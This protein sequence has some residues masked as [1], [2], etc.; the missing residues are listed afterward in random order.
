[1]GGP[2]STFCGTASLRHLLGRWHSARC[3]EGEL[4]QPVK[5]GQKERD[6]AEGYGVGAMVRPVPTLLSA[7]I[8]NGT[9]PGDPGH[10]WNVLG[11]PGYPH[12]APCVGHALLCGAGEDIEHAAL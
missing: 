3:R 6:K 5:A 10:V 11:S 9:D 7:F 2:G 1:M 8:E 12:F 4:W